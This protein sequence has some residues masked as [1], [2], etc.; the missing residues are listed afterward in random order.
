ML[1]QETQPLRVD[2]LYGISKSAAEV[3]VSRICSLNGLSYVIERV[4][5]AFGPWEH[6]SGYRDTLSPAYQL[7]RKARAGERAV[8]LRDKTSNWHYGR[9]AAAALITLSRT[10]RS[11]ASAITISDHNAPGRSADGAS[12]WP[13]ASRIPFRNRRTG[14]CRALRRQ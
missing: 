6:D 2:M 4:A 9:D 5:T 8:L 13:S 10:S 1:V 7:T 12:G 3:I 14:K 11:L